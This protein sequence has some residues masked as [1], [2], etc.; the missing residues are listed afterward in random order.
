MKLEVKY[1]EQMKITQFGLL[2]M[3]QKFI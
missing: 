2:V 1:I 3:E